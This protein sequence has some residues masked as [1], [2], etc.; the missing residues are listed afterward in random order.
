MKVFDLLVFDWDGTLFDSTG[1]I[2]EAMQLS[3]SDLGLPVPSRDAARYVIGLGLNDALRHAIPQIKPDQ[4]PQLVERYRANYAARSGAITLFEGIS[5]LIADLHACGHRLAIATGKSR[6]GLNDA[7]R[8][9][10]LGAFF[11]ATRCADEGLP[12]PDPWMLRDL[13]EETGVDP[14]KML[15]IGDTTHDLQLAR[16]AGSQFCGVTYGAHDAQALRDPFAWQVVD[17]VS[18]LSIAL[19]SGALLDEANKNAENDIA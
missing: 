3:A 18:Q 1:A 12:K 4:I 6:L 15:M 16:N 13:G 2:V 7:L 19:K 5:E 14:R 11:E 17:T 9:S 10:G 8:Q